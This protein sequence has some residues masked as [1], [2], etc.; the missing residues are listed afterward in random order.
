MLRIAT[1]VFIFALFLIACSEEP[2]TF[3]VDVKDNVRFVHSMSPKSK[4]R[5]S[6]SIEFRQKIGD[7][8][9]PDE[10]LLFYMIG[11]VVRDSKGCIYILDSNNYRIQKF[12]PDG[13]F[14]QSIG[15]KGQ[16]PGELDTAWSMDVDKNDIIYAA[17]FGN[18]RIQR[19]T[20]DGREKGSIKTENLTTN[21]EFMSDGSFVTNTNMSYL[22][23]IKKDENISGPILSLKFDSEENFL[24]GIGGGITNN[25]RSI[26]QRMNTNTFCVDENDNVY[27]CFWYENRIDKYSP[28]GELVMQITRDLDYPVEYRDRVEKREMPDGSTYD[29]KTAD[30]NNVSTK[31]I[32]VDHLERIWVPTY[33]RQLDE[34][35]SATQDPPPVDLVELEVYDH[36]GIL[37]CRIPTDFYFKR[38]R[39]FDDM[40]YFIDH[41]NKCCVYEYKI[42]N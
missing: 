29:Y 6:I 10:N 19:F 28:D 13:K 39:I 5:A 18:M 15:R 12:S 30:F 40:I 20:S 25:E 38:F 21:I 16:G 27:I 33:V 35:E 34:G 31:G 23:G 42:L 41:T 7:L 24:N 36:K 1:I 22:M 32:A 17:D 11:T 26:Q 9:S 14:M 8:E 2:A 4:D 3:T 37:L